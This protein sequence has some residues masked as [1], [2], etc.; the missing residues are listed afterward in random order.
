MSAPDPVR[1]P[2]AFHAWALL[3]LDRA[4]SREEEREFQAALA[5]SDDARRAFAQAAQADSELVEL[6]RADAEAP[7]LPRLRSGRRPMTQ[8]LWAAAALVLVGAGSILLWPRREAPP[9]PVVA[10]PAPPAVPD[11][12]EAERRDMQQ[13]LAEIEKERRRQTPEFRKP[14]EKRP[15]EQ[16]PHK[17]AEELVEEQKKIEAVLTEKETRIREKAGA[18]VAAVAQIESVS[19]AVFVLSPDKAPARGGQLLIAGNV[20][21]TE[22]DGRCVVSPALRAR[23]ELFGG[24]KATFGASPGRVVV[25]QGKLIGQT[26]KRALEIETP[27]TRFE[28]V[29]GA[30]FASVRPAWTHVEVHQGKVRVGGR[31]DV[32]AGQLA[33]EPPRA[34]SQAEIDEAIRR[35]VEW[36]KKAPSPAYDQFGIKN[37]DEFILFA[38]VRAGVPASDPRVAELLKNVLAAPLEKT[39]NVALQAMCLEEL[40]RV[41]YQPRVA[42][43]AQFLVDNQCKNGQWTYGEPT[44]FLR[45]APPGPPSPGPGK[46]KVRKLIQIRRMREGPAQGD[47]S[48]AQYAALGL[49]ACYDAGIALPTETLAL[50]RK[51]WIACQFGPDPKGGRGWCYHDGK[52]KVNGCECCRYVYSSMTAGALG[53]L[54][55]Y[56]HMLRVDWRRDGSA[57]AGLEWMANR[58]SVV[59]N[60]GWGKQIE[61]DLED[62]GAR[63]YNLYAMERVGMFTGLEKFGRHAWYAEGAAVI[64][65]RQLP[66]GSWSDFPRGVPNEPPAPVEDTCFALLFLGRATRPLQDLAT[67]GSPK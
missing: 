8:L 65:E 10:V 14:E 4:L 37:C 49:R 35:G 16:P 61:G 43:C 24:V 47:N 51:W 66:D 32:A 50:A 21:V 19:G 39:Y 44:P 60:V 12:D 36:L 27:H 2:D 9:R 53:S 26:S 25:Q 23:I 58:F 5:A 30:L 28:T 31:R 29:D 40:D 57:Q 1:D 20:V 38:L 59:H 15:V 56:D 34:P 62:E 48:N 67:P 41:R 64:L 63:F 7:R 45:N 33:L 22:G 54:V 52:G 42:D 55:I 11:A 13:R 46:P 18:T 17:T 6:C 3:F